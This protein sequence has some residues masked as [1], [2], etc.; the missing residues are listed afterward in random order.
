MSKKNC[1]R[2]EYKDLINFKELEVDNLP[3]GVS[4][5]TMCCSAKLGSTIDITN[6]QKYL[7]LD[8]NSIL[9]VKLNNDEQRTLL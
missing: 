9:S 1:K 6:I 3:V 2:Q 4:I 8:C 5:S 7:K